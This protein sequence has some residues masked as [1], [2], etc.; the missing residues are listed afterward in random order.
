MTD[1][2]FLP[3]I[4]LSLIDRGKGAELG[5]ALNHAFVHSGFCY[6]VNHGVPEPVIED[7][8]RQALAFFHLPLEEKLK[9]SPRE[10]VR[11][12]NTI[13]RT[14]MQYAEAPDYKEYYQIGLELPPDDPAVLAGQA[15]RGP[16]QWP[17]GMPA[18]RA[19]FER[20]FDEIGRCGGRLLRGVAHA[21]SA[22]EDFFA[23]KYDK[24]LQ[25]TQAV[26]Y[27][28]H[29]ADHEGE[30]FGVAPHT[31]YGCI[32]L[33]WQDEVGGLE[34]LDR[35]G[36]WVSAPPIPGTLVI[37]IGDLLQRWSN[38]RY[39]SNQHRVTNRSGRE[40]L[41]IAT[42]YDPDYSALVDPRELNLPAGVA[43]RHQPV[44]AGDYIMGRINASQ[45]HN[46]PGPAA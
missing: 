18:F 9:A 7:I 12:F 25:R 26:F 43:S 33:L 2:I 41:S 20:Y 28:P 31:D 34:V 4:D 24:P 29:P 15:M 35:K 23:G 1:D 8:H 46:G 39:F 6:L 30:L 40:R 3:T 21:L 13:G 38:D 5:K 45:R 17:A 36:R 11:G 32:T 27:P 22:P 19:A 10:A 16:N 37:N 42:F 14:K 44:S